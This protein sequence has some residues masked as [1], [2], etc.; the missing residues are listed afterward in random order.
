MSRKTGAKLEIERWRHLWRFLFGFLI[1]SAS[2]LVSF[3]ITSDVAQAQSAPT[4]LVLWNKLGS[5]QEVLNSAFGPNLAFFSGDPDCDVAD[6]LEAY[7]ANPAF[8]PG[9]FGNALTIGPGDYGGFGFA[10]VHNVVLR[11]ANQYINPERGTVEA[12]FMQTAS[13][14][15]RLYGDYRVFD[16]AY[17]FSPGIVF[18][19]NDIFGTGH[20]VFEYGLVFGGTFVEV[21][22]LS[23]DELG[24]DL[25]P[26]NGKWIHLAGVWDHN[27]ITGS[28]DTLRLYVNGEVVATASDNSWG[29][30]VGPLVDIGGGNA[31]EIAGKFAVDNLKLWNIAKTDFSDRFAEGFGEEVAVDVAPQ[32][33]DNVVNLQSN[34]QLSVAI[35]STSSFDAATINA[36]SVRLGSGGAV[37]SHSDGKLRDVNGDTR[38]DLVLSFKLQEAGVQAGDTQLCLTGNTINATPIHGCDTIQTK[39]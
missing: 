14:V 22:S 17:G 32:K 5:E 39:H 19:T 18:G 20:F 27:G 12:W 7:V 8:V 28:S 23:N 34:S 37:P 31:D 25:T 15:P 16:G 2:A 13:G 24:Y 33:T 11:N 26:Y 29:T 10:R 1:L 30:S 38:R 3:F 21:R 6:C 9:V 35:L 36:D 4:G